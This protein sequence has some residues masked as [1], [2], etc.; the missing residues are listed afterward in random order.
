[1]I[2]CPIFSPFLELIAIPGQ[3]SLALHG[4]TSASLDASNQ[5][6]FLRDTRTLPYHGRRVKGF[7]FLPWLME[8]NLPSDRANARLSR[9]SSYSSSL[10][11]RPCD[12]NELPDDETTFSHSPFSSLCAG[13]VLA[14]F[15]PTIFKYGYS[16]LHLTLTPSPFKIIQ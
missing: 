6:E 12:C 9:L 1:M 4:F 8:A 15:K 14:L 5:C 2:N 10:R 7:S 3:R 13:E 16:P 11:M